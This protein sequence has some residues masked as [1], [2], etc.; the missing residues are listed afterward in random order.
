VEEQIILFWNLFLAAGIRDVDCSQTGE[1]G[2]IS[3]LAGIRAEE[4][5]TSTFGRLASGSI[6]GENIPRDRPARG[7]VCRGAGWF[8][9][10]VRIRTSHA[11]CG[12][13]GELQWMNVAGEH[14]G[15]GIAGLLL[16][17]PSRMGSF[18]SS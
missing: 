11:R 4:W 10:R 3:T 8:D 6:C 1:D 15:C 5:E 13:G 2:D 7:S 16:W 14:R 17:R 12:C 9:R 18:S